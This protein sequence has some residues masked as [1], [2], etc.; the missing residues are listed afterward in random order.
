MIVCQRC[1]AEIP[2]GSV[3]RELAL[4]QCPSCGLVFTRTAL[5]VESVAGPRPRE[6]PA[7][8]QTARKR[9]A[10]PEHYLVEI[11]EPAPLAAGSEQAAPYRLEA[12]R[13]APTRA[14]AR[15]LIQWSWERRGRGNQAFGFLFGLGIVGVALFTA[16][17]ALNPRRANEAAIIR[18]TLGSFAVLFAAI[19]LW[20]AYFT[21]ANM[22]NTTSVSLA[23][24]VLRVSHGPLPWPGNKK[25]YASEIEQIYCES[26]QFE[27]QVNRGPARTVTAYALHLELRG[28]ATELLMR[29]FEH[30]QEALYIEQALESAMGIVDVRVEGELPR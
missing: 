5:P 4:A 29:D 9:V 25:I 14:N 7:L 18:V 28:G 27:V 12:G 24:G 19:G 20:L 16:N 10:M 30:A 11:D 23:E 13:A 8:I 26:Y 17:E 15:A 22:L 1:S 3:R 21:L 2:E 6:R